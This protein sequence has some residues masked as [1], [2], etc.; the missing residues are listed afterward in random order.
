MGRVRKAARVKCKVCGRV[1]QTVP[2]LGG[3][4]APVNPDTGEHW[5]SR[6]ARDDDVNDV[7]SAGER[8]RIEWACSRECRQQLEVRA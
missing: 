2:R 5:W 1:Q 4:V 8:R 3:R 6:A 7:P